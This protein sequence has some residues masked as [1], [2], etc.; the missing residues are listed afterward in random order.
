M[1][2]FKSLAKLFDP[3][4]NLPPRAAKLDKTVERNLARKIIRHVAANMKPYGY[5]HTKPTFLCRE[6]PLLISFFHFLLR[7]LQAGGR[8]GYDL[9]RC[10]YQI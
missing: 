2:E 6:E 1:S 4:E 7:G 8:A 5:A 10:R 9:E 3:N